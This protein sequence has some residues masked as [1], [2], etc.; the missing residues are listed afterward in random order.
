[1]RGIGHRVRY[2]ILAAGWDYEPFAHFG[3]MSKLKSAQSF[4][5][6]HA[7]SLREPSTL[8]VIRFASNSNSN[9]IYTY[10]IYSIFINDIAVG[11]ISSI[12]LFV[13]KAGAADQM[14]L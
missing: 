10:I 12:T 1:M 2:D 11:L 9:Y 14:R 4:G 5:H 7:N 3:L 8:P 13:S 6:R